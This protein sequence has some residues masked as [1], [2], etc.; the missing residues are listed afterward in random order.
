MA[1]IAALAGVSRATVSI[2]LSST[3]GATTRFKPETVARVR[4]IAEESGY[5]MNL[6]ALSLRNPHPSFFGLILRGASAAETISWHH[7]AFEGQMQAGVIEAAR[8]ARL[9]PVLAT[10]DSP[11]EGE[12]LDRVRGVLDGGVFGA[13]L[14]TPAPVLVPPMQR[15]IARGF[16]AVI[17]FP[18]DAAAFRTN[19]IDMDNLEAGRRAGHLLHEA[20]RANWL[21][22]RDDLDRQ[23][24]ALRQQGAEEVAGRSRAGV[25]IASVPFGAGEQSVM[26]DLVPILRE[27]R[28]DGIYAASSVCGAAALLAAHEAGLRI[29]DDASLVACD[30]S[31]WRPPGFAPIT[32]VDVSWFSAGEAAVRKLLELRDGEQSVFENTLLPPVVR[33]GGTCP[34]GDLEPPEV[35]FC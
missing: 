32:S 33:R 30:A 27:C 12:A 18:D 1:E 31:L 3:A 19:V 13:I 29:P 22:V 16:P 25:R 5:Q 26:Q 34:G 7:Q 17:V 2:I 35:I 21:I 23:A 15:R 28:P 9:Y 8:R 10:Q 24:L 4:Q 6:M 20:G 11:R 14:R